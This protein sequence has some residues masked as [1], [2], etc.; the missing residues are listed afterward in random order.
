MYAMRY[1][2][3]PI[4]RA[5]GGLK[6]SVIAVDDTSLAA[7]DACG[8]QFAA[9]HATALLDTIEHA[10]SL[11]SEPLIWRKIQQAAMRRDFSWHRSA[12]QYRRLYDE[13]AAAA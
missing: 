10:L 5:V 8:F 13:V 2:T 9:A 12:T 7:G 4:V 3:V 11:F 6:D 1:G